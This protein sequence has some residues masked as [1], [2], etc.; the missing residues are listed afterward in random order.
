MIITIDINAP[1]ICEFINQ[2]RV[3][4]ISLVQ[5]FPSLANTFS[6]GDRANILSDRRTSCPQTAVG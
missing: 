2:D 6:L 5:A 3:S 4:S 1:F